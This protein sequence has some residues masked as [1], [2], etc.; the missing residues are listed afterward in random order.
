MKFE[1]LNLIHPDRTW[2]AEWRRRLA[3]HKTIADRVSE[4]E[5]T[6]RQ[7]WLS[8]FNEVGQQFPPREVALL[9]VKD[10]R[11][12]RVLVRGAN[13]APGSA[14]FQ[15]AQYPALAASGQLGPKRRAGD[16]QVPEG[17]YR[18]ESLNPNS[19]YYLSLRLNYPNEDDRRWAR[20]DGRQNLGGDIMIHGN[21]VSIGCVAIG[22]AAIA[23]LFFL[24]AITDSSNWE[25]VI[26]PTNLSAGIPEQLLNGEI[27]RKELYEKLAGRLREFGTIESVREL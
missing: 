3:G 21:S 4:L 9:Y 1:I 22:D 26:T 2:F 14:W 23:E 15:I 13:S 20:I 8:R 25:V 16:L 6:Q 19:A 12:L 10:E 27:W 7:I 17:L 18:I 5:P 24:A 11:R